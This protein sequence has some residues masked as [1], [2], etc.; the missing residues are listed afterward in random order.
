[1]SDILCWGGSSTAAPTLADGGGEGDVHPLSLFELLNQECNSFPSK[2]GNLASPN[3][4][5]DSRCCEG[6]RNE[7]AGGKQ[8]GAAGGSPGGARA[9]T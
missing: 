7:S 5:A 9:A 8:G 6:K 3:G 1:M 2:T 4:P